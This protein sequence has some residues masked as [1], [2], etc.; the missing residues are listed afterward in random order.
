MIAFERLVMLAR[1]ELPED[2]TLAVEDHVLGCDGCAA[3]LERLLD[4]GDAIAQVTRTGGAFL[5]AGPALVNR[6]E[7]QRMVTRTYRIAPGG[8]VSCTVGA[9]DVYTAMHLALDTHGVERLDLVYESPSASYRVEDLP[10]DPAGGELVFVQP[11]EYLRTLST[12]RKT[13]RLVAVD[14]EGERVVG[15]Y[16]LNHTAYVP[17][18]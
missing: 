8:Q 5:L 6:L 16:V 4:L 10:F 2:E 18:T 17:G 1:G 14:D 7:Q 11:A 12:E 15:E 13:L 9:Q 3:L